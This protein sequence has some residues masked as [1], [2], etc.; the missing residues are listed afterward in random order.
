MPSDRS[1]NVLW[2][3]AGLAVGGAMGVMLAPRPGAQ[4]RRYLGQRAGQAGVYLD[5]GRQLYDRGRELADEA[6]QLYEEGRHL[7][8]G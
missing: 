4:T 6:A 8:E 5:R 7:I 2:F 1:P 3:V